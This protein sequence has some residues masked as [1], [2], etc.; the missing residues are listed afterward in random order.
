M[1]SGPRNAAVS[2]DSGENKPERVYHPYVFA[3]YG[4]E[5]IE[6]RYGVERH[7]RAYEYARGIAE[8]DAA[9]PPLR[10]EKLGEIYGDQ[11]PGPLGQPAGEDCAEVEQVRRRC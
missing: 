2:Y 1:V 4:L 3:L 6:Q 10:G 11:A 9:G 8:A 5:E 7:P